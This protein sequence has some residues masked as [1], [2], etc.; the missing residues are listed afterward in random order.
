MFIN[1]IHLN[2]TDE[3][4]EQ[5]ERRS[6]KR[7]SPLSDLVLRLIDCSLLISCLSSWKTKCM[8]DSVWQCYDARTYIYIRTHI[9][10]RKCHARLSKNRHV[11]SVSLVENFPLVAQSGSKT[12]SRHW[13]FAVQ[14]SQQFL[15]Q[16]RRRERR[17]R[18]RKRHIRC[19]C[20]SG[21]EM[22]KRLHAVA[23]LTRSWRGGP[24]RIFRHRYLTTVY[25][26]KRTL[27]N[28]V[29]NIII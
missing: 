11:R 28:I 19:V 22:V 24:G 25:G 10:W 2:P 13:R 1:D 18:K 29:G 15:R 8:N 16:E 12:R 17:T 6:S 3:F 23:Y 5:Y 7:E 9:Y 21:D 26:G 4:G 14:R 27:E 20:V